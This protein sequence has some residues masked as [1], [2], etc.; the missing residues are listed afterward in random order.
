MPS[1]LFEEAGLSRWDISKSVD[2]GGAPDLTRIRALEPRVR[3]SAVDQPTQPRPAGAVA[4]RPRASAAAPAAQSVRLA[5]G[6]LG[7]LARSADALIADLSRI[8]ISL[9]RLGARQPQDAHSI[10]IGSSALREVV[11][12]M[13]LVVTAADALVAGDL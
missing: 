6:D 2:R 5:S 1:G 3:L 4:A 10:E 13:K 11:R 7:P 9:S 8:E 12:R